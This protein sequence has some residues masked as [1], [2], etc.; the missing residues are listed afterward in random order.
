MSLN[1]QNLH[2]EQKDL[3]EKL[4]EN[5]KQLAHGW[6][7]K[8]EY[9]VPIRYHITTCSVSNRIRN[10]DRCECPTKDEKRTR[11]IKVDGLLD[12]LKE[13]LK[14]KDV[15]RN[16]Q[17]ARQAPRVKKPKTNSDLNGFFTL[18]EITCDAYATIDRIYED[19]GRDRMLATQPIHEVIGSLTYQM[20]QIVDSR[21][22]LVRDAIKATG[23]WVNMARRTLN[24]QVAD[25]MFEGVVCDNC[26]GAL[27]IAW[28]NAS[29]VKCIGS[30]SAPSC[31]HTYP[32]GE[33][34]SLYEKR[35]R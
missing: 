9:T 22:D 13:Y 34:M 8:T 30:P 26:G 17:A 23:K 18:D 31:G 7:E 11:H 32:M 19:G 16:P 35:Q 14:S 15:D 20:G 6:R 1:F 2:G 33:W 25:A 28:D 3:M 5:V 24:L 10:G 12:Q 27:S 29:D 4:Y 21:P